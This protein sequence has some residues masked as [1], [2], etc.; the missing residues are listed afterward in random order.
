MERLYLAS[1]VALALALLALGLA[2]I[3]VTTASGGGPGAI[4]VVGGVALA[5]LGFLRLVLLRRRR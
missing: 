3:A 2:M 5:T 4:G 1:A